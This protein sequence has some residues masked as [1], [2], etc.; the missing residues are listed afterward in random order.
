MLLIHHQDPSEGYTLL[1]PEGELDAFTVAPFRRVLA[2]VADSGRLIIDLSKVTFIDSAGLG[3]LIGGLRH[4]RERG[5]QV[6][7]AC[8]RPGLIGVFQRTGFDAVATI[9]TTL[10]EA[11]EAMASTRG[12]QAPAG[13]GQERSPKRSR[14]SPSIGSPPVD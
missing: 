1:Q 14:V 8:S 7:V 6:A 12:E 11:A 3:A 5:G 2:A 4:I 9:A 13:S 10:D